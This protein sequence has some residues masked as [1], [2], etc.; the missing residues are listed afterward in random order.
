MSKKKHKPQ[1]TARK[2][3]QDRNQHLEWRTYNI[4]MPE[5]LIP[6]YDHLQGELNRILSDEELMRKILQVDTGLKKGD[7][8]RELRWIIGD[9]FL[10]W[11]YGSNAWY[12]RMVYEN[13]R[14]VVTSGAERRIVHDLLVKHGNEPDDGFWD[15]LYEVGAYPKHGVVRNI[16][17]EIKNGCFT[18][19]PTSA[20]FVMD[21]TAVS[22]KAIERKVSQNRWL[23]RTGKVSWLDIEI[24]LP[25]NVRKQATGKV[26]KPRFMRKKLTGEYTGCVSYEVLVP[27]ELSS[28]K[29]LGVDLGK[30]KPF[31]AS[32]LD[33]DGRVSTEYVISKRTK[34]LFDKYGRIQESL[35]RLLA[36]QVRCE[37]LDTSEKFARRATEI[38]EVRAKC[39]RLRD[40]ITRFVALDIVLCALAEDCGC[41]HVERLSW[42]DARGGRW[43][44][45][46][47]QAAVESVAPLFGLRV[48]KVDAA[49]S[50]RVDP[51]SG[52]L[53]AECGRAVV[54]ADGWVVDRDYLATVNLACRPVVA[55]GECHEV[56]GSFRVIKPRRARHV[57]R[58][59]GSRVCRG[60]VEGESFGLSVDYY[61]LLKISRFPSGGVDVVAFS[62]GRGGLLPTRS[63]KLMANTENQACKE[64]SSTEL[65]T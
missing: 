55:D 25:K 14:R 44:H 19:Y 11:G 32:A 40:E 23:F 18:A 10:E 4:P 48:Y 31:S 1:A 20:I 38:D 42:L 33:G 37:G 6:I 60:V 17:R 59:S 27:N 51:T 24:L 62:A 39:R 21:Y 26:A 41:V 16:Q 57:R 5:A 2:G 52:E 28:E 47:V 58:K 7:Y 43:N 49:Y 22:D 50:S 61:D 8:W 65:V 56:D 3:Q 34:H 64:I 46:E 15:E 9:G 30:V 36:K 63:I 35:S 13:I 29:I 45:S 12:A 53:G 54:F